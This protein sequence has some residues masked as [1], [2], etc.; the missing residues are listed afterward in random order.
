[1]KFYAATEFCPRLSA[2]VPPPLR[3][4]NSNLPQQEVIL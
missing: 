4:K 2:R 1:L 3:A